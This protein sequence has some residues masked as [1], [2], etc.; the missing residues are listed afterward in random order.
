MHLFKNH[1]FVLILLSSLSL[2]ACQTVTNLIPTSAPQPSPP[3]TALVVPTSFVP[4]TLQI[5]PTSVKAES[6]PTVDLNVEFL[7]DFSNLE[8][9]WGRVSD[10]VGVSDY[11]Q[12]GYRI[13]VLQN[14]N[15]KW[16][17]VSREYSNV[18]VE[19]DANLI[20]G[21]E[22]NSLGV[23]CRYEDT[24][25]FY[26]F[27]IS[28]DG[29]FAIRKRVDGGS[30]TILGSES[31]Q[32][33]EFIRLGTE[34]NRIVVECNGSSLRL[35]VNDQLLIEVQDIDISFGKVGLIVS[36]FGVDST[37]ILFDNFKAVPL[38]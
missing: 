3:P 32:N 11:F 16:S 18:R 22:D 14:N 20:G 30:I 1:S 38:P 7:D 8:S 28:S 6:S 12:E 37:D 29:F 23:I 35:S 13:S 2:F 15:F 34:T 27:V 25:N 36:T 21:S 33:S 10:E 4:P 17:V 5:A 31:F 26:A 19:V 24:N 9:G